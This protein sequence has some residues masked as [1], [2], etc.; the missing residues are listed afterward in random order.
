MRRIV[1]KAVWGVIQIL[2]GFAI[3]IGGVMNSDYT[4]FGVGLIVM[5]LPA[6]NRIE[7]KL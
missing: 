6:L 2:V 3:S 5:S 1:I 7:E 4:Q